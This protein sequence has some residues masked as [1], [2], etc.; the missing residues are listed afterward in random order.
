MANTAL[1][2]A[3]SCASLTR[4]CETERVGNRYYKRRWDETR[5]DRY[6]SWGPATYLFEVGDDG[7][8][9]R[10]V[11]IYDA[12]PR[13]RYGPDHSADEYGSLG[14]TQIDE[15]EDWAPWAISREEFEAIWASNQ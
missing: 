2:V 5:G 7:W 1:P 3:S 4:C 15:L 10:Q 9:I 13:L 14:Q 12:G 11:E 8:P 6:E